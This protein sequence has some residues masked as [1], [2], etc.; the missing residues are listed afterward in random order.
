LHDTSIAILALPCNR[1]LN[2]HLRKA[3]LSDFD[4]INNTNL[5]ENILN[6]T[7]IKQVKSLGSS[8]KQSL[9]LRIG[10]TWFHLFYCVLNLFICCTLYVYVLLTIQCSH[11]PGAVAIIR[12]SDISLKVNTITCV[13]W[14]QKPNR[15]LAKE[16]F[17]TSET[18]YHRRTNNWQGYTRTKKK[19]YMNNTDSI[20]TWIQ[21]WW[22]GSVSIPYIF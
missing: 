14:G 10:G 4:N 13:I 8:I 9:E 3:F 20:K 16:R 1:A 21:S 11:W 19:T 18:R 15:L 2:E 17:R 5:L 6:P 12:Q 22:T 7:N